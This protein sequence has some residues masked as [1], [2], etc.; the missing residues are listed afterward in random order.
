[1]AW[2]AD[3]AFVAEVTLLTEEEWV[4][5]VTSL[6]EV[7]KDLGNVKKV[8][9]SDDL[10]PIWDKVRLLISKRRDTF[11]LTSALVVLR[12]VSRMEG[13]LSRQGNLVGKGLCAHPYR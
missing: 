1:M 4:E 12:C 13:P 10:T 6:L 11:F 2:H 3:S 7:L 8:P 9:Q 5:E